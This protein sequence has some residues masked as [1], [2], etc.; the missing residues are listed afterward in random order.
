MKCN[1][2]PLI[3]IIVPVYNVEL[4]LA[5]CINSLL[6]QT[7]KNIEII[8]V[9]DGST[10][11]SSFI[12][13]QYEKRSSNI[14]LINNSNK[15]LS[16]ARNEGIQHAQ[17]DYIIFVDSD[18]I[19]H[20]DYLKILFDLISDADISVCEVKNFSEKN[21]IID[22]NLNFQIY[23][24]LTGD[25]F[26]EHLYQHKFGRL[27]ILVTNKLYKK[28]LWDEIEF[29]LNRF[30]EDCFTIYKVTDKAKKIVIT[31]KPLY[32]YRKRAG[33]IT[34]NRTLKSV[35]DEYEAISQQINFFKT[36]NQLNIVKNANRS[37]KNLFL[38]K[39]VTNHWIIWKEYTIFN[40]L[41]D[42]IRTKTKVKL[43]AKKIKSYF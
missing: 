28:D 35:I 32:Y 23:P 1:A 8:L 6:I 30:H 13:K 9:N 38:D 3:S 36:K 11:K 20:K 43:I 34:F 25:E 37:R 4:Y 14:I 12:C 29:P 18:D 21:P 2:N 24:A 17:G 33:S 42:D 41:Q 7:Y 40:I 5:E 16:A 22:E 31:D 10:D 19:I 26:N 15:G 39:S 27:A